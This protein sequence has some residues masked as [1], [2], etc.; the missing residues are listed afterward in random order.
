MNK[1]L[2]GGE[3]MTDLRVVWSTIDAANRINTFLNFFSMTTKVNKQRIYQIFKTLQGEGAYIVIICCSSF[4]KF[5]LIIHFKNML[6]LS[7][8]IYKK[9][10]KGGVRH[11]EGRGCA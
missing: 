11:E 7:K 10:F 5:L 6:K 3:A 9:N 4:M 1:N 2:K 8:F